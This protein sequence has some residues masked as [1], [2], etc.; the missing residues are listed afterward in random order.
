MLRGQI[1]RGSHGAVPIDRI[2]K[3]GG[4]PAAV[5][6]GARRGQDLGGEQRDGEHGLQL[7]RLEEIAHSRGV[8]T[9]TPP[10]THLRPPLRPPI[11]PLPRIPIRRTPPPRRRPL[12]SLRRSRPRPPRLPP[13]RRFGPRQ[14]RMHPPRH[15]QWDGQ[16][17]G[18]RRG[19]GGVDADDGISRRGGTRAG[20]RSEGERE[21]ISKEQGETAEGM[22]TDRGKEESGDQTTSE[23]DRTGEIGHEQSRRQGHSDGEGGGVEIDVGKETSRQDQEDGGRNS[24]AQID[25]CQ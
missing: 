16:D 12:R 24:D 7:E 4:G 3:V 21:G 23:G 1:R 10:H 13:I 19:R 20:D 6:G 14:F 22:R 8:P 11:L 2:A 25:E 5:G 17:D 15:S 18:S 9:P